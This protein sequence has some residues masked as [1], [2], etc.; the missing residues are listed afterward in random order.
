MATIEQLRRYYSALPDDELL[1][2]SEAGRDA[3][4]TYAWAAIEEQLQ[5]RHLALAEPAT[6]G[7]AAGNGAPS[8]PSVPVPAVLSEAA[9][10]G[11]VSVRGILVF[12]LLA[13]AVVSVAAAAVVPD[14]PIVPKVVRYIVLLFVASQVMAGRNWARVLLVFSLTVSAVV[15]LLASIQSAFGNFLW[16]LMFGAL[17][18]A[19]GS[20]ALALVWSPSIQAFFQESRRTR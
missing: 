13:S 15:G 7:A 14:P 18:I 11:R 16:A 5:H 1:A 8:P 3:Y 19:E 9:L 20:M 6:V 10:R 12:V 4:E 2:A 17:S